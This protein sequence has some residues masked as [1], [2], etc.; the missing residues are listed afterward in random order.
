MR[1]AIRMFSALLLIFCC[2]LQATAQQFSV[3]T[4]LKGNLNWPVTDIFDET[5][6]TF[7]GQAGLFPD[8]DVTVPDRLGGLNGL[9]GEVGL[10]SHVPRFG[11]VGVTFGYGCFKY[12]RFTSAWVYT[13][14]PDWTSTDRLRLG[15]VTMPLT[16]HYE[17]PCRFVDRLN[18]NTGFGVDFMRSDH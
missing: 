13:P 17:W 11:K 12:K 5:R 15:L 2:T 14:S 18:W 9:E 16:I 10:F 3:T 4:K 7:Q 1:T 8:Y 6:D